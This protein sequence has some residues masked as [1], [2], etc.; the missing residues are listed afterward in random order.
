MQ[1]ILSILQK[2]GDTSVKHNDNGD[3]FICHSHHM[4]NGGLLEIRH[5]RPDNPITTVYRMDIFG[6]AI[7]IFEV[8]GDETDELLYDRH[9]GFGDQHKAR[10]ETHTMLNLLAETVT[11]SEQARFYT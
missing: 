9:S 4:H 11:E 1:V 6:E 10:Q 5:S 2:P 3:R 7:G 8:Y